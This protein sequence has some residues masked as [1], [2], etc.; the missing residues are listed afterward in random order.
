MWQAPTIPQIWEFRCDSFRLGTMDAYAAC[1]IR[2]TICSAALYK[3]QQSNQ[4][5]KK[6]LTKINIAVG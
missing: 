4:T 1:R 5:D 2:P 3:Q 6:P